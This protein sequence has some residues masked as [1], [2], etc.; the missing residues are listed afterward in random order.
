MDFALKTQAMPLALLNFKQKISQKPKFLA[1]WTCGD[2]R[3]N[4]N[5]GNYRIC[6]QRA[7]MSGF[8]TRQFPHKLGF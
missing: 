6:A 4:H 1:L 7:R 3:W 2:Q 5:K 8:P